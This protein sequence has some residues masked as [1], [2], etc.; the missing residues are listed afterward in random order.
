MD[1]ILKLF[2]KEPNTEFHIR[3]I[4]KLLKKSPTTISKYLKNYEK[5]EILES[6]KK[7]NHLLFKA[8]IEGKKFKR[9]KLN[10]NLESI[11]KSNLIDFLEEKFKHPRA[12]VLFGSFAKAEN[13]NE[14][15]IDILVVS[16]TKIDTNKIELNKFE[17]EIGNEIQL[18]AYTPKEIK[19]LKLT[20]KELLN[21]WI[22]GIVLHGYLEI[23]K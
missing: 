3:Q 9:V 6:T 13:I 2:I 16:P 11:E 20:N 8:N 15:D 21:N 1:K 22:N 17:N 10:Y 14:S 18:F 23:L 5:K 7:F 4:A 12:I 19:K